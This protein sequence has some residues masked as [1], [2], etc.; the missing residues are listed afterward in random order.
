M[1]GRVPKIERCLAGASE[2]VLQTGEIV[3]LVFSFAAKDARPSVGMGDAIPPSVNACINNAFDDARIPVDP[4]Y[5]DLSFPMTLRLCLHGRAPSF[6]ADV[7][8]GP[9]SLE[10]GGDAA[11][12][13]A[14]VQ[15]RLETIQRC[16]APLLHE[17]PTLRGRLHIRLRIDEDGHTRVLATEPS[18]SPPA[19]TSCVTRSLSAARF[20]ATGH[21]PVTAVVPL[22]LSPSK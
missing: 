17:E 22:T 12:I 14:A 20:D 3:P 11:P 15:A 16:Y 2:P 4:R 19:L 13:E 9:V 8:L 7:R 21:G 6:D 18:T 5:A 10:E 1:K